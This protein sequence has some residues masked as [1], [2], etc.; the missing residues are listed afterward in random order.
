MFFL[1]DKRYTI[2]RVLGYKGDIFKV[3]SIQL[4]VRFENE[5]EAWI[6]V[7]ATLFNMDAVWEFMK[8]NT[9]LRHIHLTIQQ[10]NSLFQSLLRDPVKVEHDKK[11]FVN[12][13][14]WGEEWFSDLDLPEKFTTIYM[15]EGRYG[16]RHKIGKRHLVDIEFPVLDESFNGKYGVNGEFVYL[17]GSN[18]TWNN[19]WTLVDNAFLLKYPLIIAE[20]KRESLIKKYKLQFR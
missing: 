9:Q 10:R 8:S 4:W 14:S 11:C 18:F 12:L 13:R 15:V 3:T 19:S 16:H 1:D 20:N 7:S 6:P 2:S 5:T 17:W